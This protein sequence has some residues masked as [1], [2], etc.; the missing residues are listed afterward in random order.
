[1]QTQTL[2]ID[3][4]TDILISLNQNIAEFGKNLKLWAAISL[5][6]YGKLSISKAADLAGYH[7]YDFENI[8]ADLNIPI[9]NL[10][11]EDINKELELLKNL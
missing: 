11:E 10:T 6:Q 8:L 4:R 3:I 9:S 7:R 2:N 5:F 1:M